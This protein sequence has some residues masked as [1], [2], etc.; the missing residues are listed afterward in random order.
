MTGVVSK[1]VI[2]RSLP[3]L[4]NIRFTRVYKEYSSVLISFRFETASDSFGWM[5]LTFQIALYSGTLA[6]FI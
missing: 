6:L 1:E 3:K 4:N 5:I 2:F